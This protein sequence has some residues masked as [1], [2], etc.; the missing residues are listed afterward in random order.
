MRI[1]LTIIDALD[2]FGTNS[3]TE[4]KV[5]A[6]FIGEFIEENDEYITLRYR[7]ENILD[8]E[9]ENEYHNI[10]KSTILNQKSVEIEIN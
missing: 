10:V 6:R 1:K 7:E 4:N 3:I 5:I 9:C 8:K 2:H